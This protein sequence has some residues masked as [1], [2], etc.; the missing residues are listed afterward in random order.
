MTTR[1]FIGDDFELA[2][3]KIFN[4]TVVG[5]IRDGGKDLKLKAGSISFVQVKASW[6]GAFEFLRTM[7]HRKRFIPLCIG[8]PSNNADEM[9]RSIVRYGAWIGQDIPRRE[10]LLPAV[11]Q[12]R[13]LCNG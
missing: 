8:E 10:E 9:I 12:I 4:A 7:L 3:A 11:A 13:S 2:Y 1:Q 6:S 5:G